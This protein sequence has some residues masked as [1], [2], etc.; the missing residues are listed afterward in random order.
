MTVGVRETTEAYTV[1]TVVSWT[2]GVRLGPETLP[3]VVDGTTTPT[4]ILYNP[5]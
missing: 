5:L 4:L 1:D 3:D 2:G